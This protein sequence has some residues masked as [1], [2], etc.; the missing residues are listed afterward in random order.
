MTN[1]SAK[2]FFSGAAAGFVLSPVFLSKFVELG[3][4]TSL[5]PD[6]TRW[7]GNWWLGF[8]IFGGLSALWSLWLS[9][10]PKEFP[11]TKKQRE[12]EEEAKRNESTSEDV[13]YN[14]NLGTVNIANHTKINFHRICSMY[15]PL[16]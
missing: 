16:L 11:M 14:K 10:F 6:D 15:L 5:T 2:L 13:S 4:Q 9:A 12:E 1:R 3:V 7:V 8:A